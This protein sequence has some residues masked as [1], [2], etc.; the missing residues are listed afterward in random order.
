MIYR[1]DLELLELLMQSKFL[2]LEIQQRVW[3]RALY[4]DPDVTDPNALLWLFEKVEG[5]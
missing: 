2:S 1:I 5:F 4:A 3:K